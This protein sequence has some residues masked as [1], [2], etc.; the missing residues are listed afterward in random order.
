MAAIVTEFLIPLMILYGSQRGLKPGI[1]LG[2][3]EWIM[4]VIRR[5]VGVLVGA[6]SRHTADEGGLVCRFHSSRSSATF[7][8]CW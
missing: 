3:P 1:E 6:D 2:A 7:F 4:H 5:L 8:F